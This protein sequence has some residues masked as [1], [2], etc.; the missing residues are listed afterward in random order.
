MP[1]APGLA[2]YSLDTSIR[3]L[4]R[5]V[6][7][8]ASVVQLR[9]HPDVQL[10]NL[11]VSGPAIFQGMPPFWSPQKNSMTPTAVGFLSCLLAQSLL[12]STTTKHQPDHQSSVCIAVGH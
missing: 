5:L 10:H 11:I 3:Y 9:S 6:L 4:L 8:E 1:A 7:Y 12:P 2:G